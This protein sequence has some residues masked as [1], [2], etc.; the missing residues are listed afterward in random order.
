MIHQAVWFYISSLKEVGGKENIN[1]QIVIA[2]ILI[3]NCD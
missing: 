1:T 3:N 2:G